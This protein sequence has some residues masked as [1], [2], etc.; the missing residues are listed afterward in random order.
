MC[1][2]IDKH[3]A[4]LPLD[5]TWLKTS[6]FQRLSDISGKIVGSLHLSESWYE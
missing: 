5:R 1:G 4:S 2:F 3:Y 6:H